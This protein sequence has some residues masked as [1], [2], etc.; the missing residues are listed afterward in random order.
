[1]LPPPGL[2]G[3]PPGAPPMPPAMPPGGT[4]AATATQPMAGSATQ[5]V[6][7]VKLGLEAMQKALPGL[8]MGSELHTAVLKSI[9]EISKHIE[10][11]E[12]DSS[13]IVQ[14]LAQ[15]AKSAQQQPQQAA[16]M[17]AFPPSQPGAGAPPP[18]PGA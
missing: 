6:S 15:M 4:G 8:P 14:Q 16:M 2:P 1:M 11:S 17:R 13:S 12:G 7:A 10:K 9:A 18:P 3:A 5:A